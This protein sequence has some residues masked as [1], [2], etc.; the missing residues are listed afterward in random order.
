MDSILVKRHQRRRGRIVIYLYC[1]LAIGLIVYLG[2]F[3]NSKFAKLTMREI[4]YSLNQSARHWRTLLKLFFEI[5]LSLVLAIGVAIVWPLVLY[6]QYKAMREK[7]KWEKSQTLSVSCG[8]L[9]KR[10]TIVEI[11]E[12]ERVVDPCNA[13]PSSPFGHLNS[14]WERFKANIREGDEIW[15]FRANWDRG[16]AKQVCSGY[17]LL[18]GNDVAHHFMTGWVE[19]KAAEA[20]FNEIEQKR[21]K[22]KIQ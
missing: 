5:I 9:I 1:H 12:L 17:A 10:M 7:I 19:G 22:A 21:C 11:E 14:V 4:M 13:V 15:T 20:M 16:W 6:T 3:S 8:G 2:I 18:R